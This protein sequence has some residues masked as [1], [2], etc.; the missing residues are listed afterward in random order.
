MEIPWRRAQLR[1][2]EF[3][4]AQ[5]ET[6]ELTR[7]M[8]GAALS[9][10][11]CTVAHLGI[12]DHI[13]AGVPRSA[14]YLAKAT[15]CHERSLYRALRFLAGHGL[16]QETKNGD[17]DHSVLSRALRSDVEGSYRA[18][19]LLFHNQFAAW[20]A[21]DHSVRTGEPGFAK[22]FGKP[23]FDYLGTHP[24]V[25]S[26]FDAGMTSIN[27]Y[28]TAAMTEAYDFG[29]IEIL[30][31]IGGG[32]GSLLGPVLQRYPRMRGMLFDQ[33]HVAARAKANLQQYDIA[34]RCQ[35]IEG[36][37]FEAIP[38]GADAYLFRHILH[39]WTDAQCLQ[40]LGHCRN[41]IPKHGKLL[42]VECVIPVGNDRSSAKDFDMSMMVFTGGLERTELEYRALFKQAGFELT[43]I[44]PT[45]TVVSVIEGK[46]IPAA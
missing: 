9:R 10:V 19:A 34:A 26:V 42:V 32:N 5:K 38:S 37:F 22:A 3:P 2:E 18:G 27:C 45:S 4:V 29:A 8:L 24:E 17:F 28:E 39:D 40:I 16:F 7:M 35:V 43:S 1:A 13:Q 25:A 11:I 20:D 12:A 14:A 23:L 31:D 21:L 41:A 44:T 30:A 6:D 46:P 36:S 15:N 33:G